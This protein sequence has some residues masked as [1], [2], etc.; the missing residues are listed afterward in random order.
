MVQALRERGGWGGRPGEPIIWRSAERRNVRGCSGF[1]LAPTGLGRVCVCGSFAFRAASLACSS[2]T[3][4]MQ[5]ALILLSMI[6]KIWTFFKA[7]SLWS[8][9]FVAPSTR[10]L[11]TV[12]NLPAPSIPY[13]GAMGYAGTGKT[14]G[15]GVR[16]QE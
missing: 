9:A 3:S 5:S 12:L 13:A 14:G 11:Y 2:F 6:S 10:A 7:T 1:D 8:D 15:G 16:G 4:L